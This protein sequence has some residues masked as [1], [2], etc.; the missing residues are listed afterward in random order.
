GNTTSLISACRSTLAAG[1]PL[2]PT[3][4]KISGLDANCN[5]TSGY[6]IFDLS[7]AFE[8]QRDPNGAAGGIVTG[9]LSTHYQ[10]DGGLG[11]V[12]YRLNDK[13]TINGK[14]FEGKHNGL[15]INNQ[16][17]T[18]PY[19]APTDVATVQFAGA[20]W[21]HIINSALVNS[22]RFGFNR[23]YQTFETSDCGGG[24]GA[25]NYGIPFGYGDSKPNCGFTNISLSPFSGSIGCCSSFPKVYGADHI[26]EVMEGLSY[27]R[28][29]HSFK[30]GGE[31]R[32][33]SIG[34]G[35]T[36]N[37]GRGQV[38]FSTLENFMAGIPTANNQILLGD[39]RRNPYN[40]SWAAYIQ[41][42]WRITPRVTL[43]L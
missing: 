4:L 42:D 14:Y 10:V 21:V 41:D 11:K 3:S 27:L 2:S 16:T 37:R 35:G 12:D 15:V 23:F 29:K 39:P 6:S 28:G 31:W 20:E 7:S 34:A 5:R 13:D 38:T 24:N 40:K 33:T 36:F 18:Q 8:R 17:I 9:S 32:S 30:F 1:R 22:F 25:T 43:N 26:Y 19:W